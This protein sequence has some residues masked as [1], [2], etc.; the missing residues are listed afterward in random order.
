ML[1]ALALVDLLEGPSGSD[2]NTELVVSGPEVKSA[3][4]IRFDLL[5]VATPAL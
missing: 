1:V 3:A 4:L 5:V 2:T